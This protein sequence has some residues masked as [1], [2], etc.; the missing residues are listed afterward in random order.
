MSPCPYA[1]S[2]PTVS[3]LLNTGSSPREPLSVRRLEPLSAPFITQAPAPVTASPLL[4]TGSSPCQPLSVRRLQPQLPAALALP[5]E[6]RLA[7]WLPGTRAHNIAQLGW[8]G[9]EQSCLEFIGA[10][11]SVK[12]PIQMDI[13]Y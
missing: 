8:N 2:S 9:L 11:L 1:G 7:A 5:V 4:Y 13:L 6:S 10:K 3:P 12:I